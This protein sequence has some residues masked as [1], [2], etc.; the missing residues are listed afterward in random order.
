MVTVPHSSVALSEPTEST[1]V[2]QRE[3][4]HLAVLQTLRPLIAGLHRTEKKNVCWKTTS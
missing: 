3:K 2:Y 4:I 1:I